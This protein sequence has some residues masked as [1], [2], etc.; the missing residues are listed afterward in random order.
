MYPMDFEEFLMA[1]GINADTMSYLRGCY[2][3]FNEVDPVVHDRIM[4]A[5]NTYLIIGG[6]PEAVEAYVRTNNI[7]DVVRV[8]KDI[9][10]NYL[11][12]ISKYNRD[13][14]VLIQDIYQLIPSELNNQNKRFI[15]KELNQK[16]R[17]YKYESSSTWLSNSGVG[18]FAYNVDEPKYPL[19]ASKERALF[20]LFPSD[21]GLLSCKLLNGNQIRILNGEVNLNF[22]S[23]YESVTAQELAA[24][25]FQLFYYNSKKTGEID[26][27]IEHEGN[28]I[29]IEVKSGKDC[30]EAF[31]S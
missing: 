11:R 3:N 27:L 18:I 25:G 17:F 29:A 16:A 14:S 2:D 26:F 6:K 30:K 19:L 7:Q 9:D 31:R 10:S 21:V 8:Q 22:G 13:Q 5:F 28:V 12:H 15:L 1:V 4:K 23:I 24:H 20:K